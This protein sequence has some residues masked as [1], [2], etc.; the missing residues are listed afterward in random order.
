MFN[1]CWVFMRPTVSA[2]V[3]SGH[4]WAICELAMT[5]QA[6]MARA[7]IE[8]LLGAIV[9]GSFLKVIFLLFVSDGN[10]FTWLR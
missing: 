8:L 1:S 9:A 4:E 7:S 3:W 10:R 6:I 5:R 2:A